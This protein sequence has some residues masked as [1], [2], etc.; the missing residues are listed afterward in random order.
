[1]ALLSTANIDNTKLRS[2]LT[3]IKR[4]ELI[5]LSEACYVPG[6]TVYYAQLLEACGLSEQA[7]EDFA[8][9]TWS[10]R[11]EGKWRKFS[12]HITLFF[13]WLM[14]YC[15][16]QDDQA[17]S[18]SAVICHMIRQYG[19]LFKKYLKFCNP[20]VFNDT[21]DRLTKTHLFYREKTIP[22]AISYLSNEL[23]KKFV[24]GIRVWDL[25]KIS[26]FITESRHR[27]NQSMKSFARSYYK[28]EKR[29]KAYEGPY[30]AEGREEASVFGLDKMDLLASHV[31]KL[32][33]VKGQI[34][35]KALNAAKTDTEISMS[36]ATLIVNELSNKTTSDRYYEDVKLILELFLKGLPS[37][38]RLNEAGYLEK[39][40]THLMSVKRTTKPIYFKKQVQ[41]LLITIIRNTGCENKFTR[42][43]NQT[44]FLISKFLAYYITMVLRNLL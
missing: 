32:I 3:R 8:H 41:E 13:I 23:E 19:N 12:D 6:Y 39:Y 11:R 1:M 35:E 33:C 4:E 2:I 16:N 14:W 15:L 10:G 27:L 20:D 38:K 36:M 37:I 43:T 5:K 40:L 7:I 21:L 44:Q 24:D 25:D 30:E 22:Q 26:A 17:T 42:L 28:N 31:S 9:L 18:N 34:D 29:S